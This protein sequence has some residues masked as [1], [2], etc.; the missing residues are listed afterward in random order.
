MEMRWHADG[1]L[2]V[3]KPPSLT[4]RYS[5]PSSL[6][7]RGSH[8]P[9]LSSGHACS[10]LGHMP[11]VNTD[12]DP[13]LEWGILPRE[14]VPGVFLSSEQLVLL[15]SV[16]THFSSDKFMLLVPSLTF[17]S[18]FPV[19]SCS[20]PGLPCR[21]HSSS[22]WLS[23]WFYYLLAAM[24]CGSF[25]A[26]YFSLL[27]ISF[28]PSCLIPQI[29]AICPFSGN[30]T[31]GRFGWAGKSG[32]SGT[33]IRQEPWPWPCSRLCLLQW[34]QAFSTLCAHSLCSLA[35][36]HPRH[37]VALLAKTHMWISLKILAQLSISQ[38]PV[39]MSCPTWGHTSTDMCLGE[40]IQSYH[41]WNMQSNSFLSL[42]PAE[43]ALLLNA[44][45]LDL[46]PGSELVKDEK[47]SINI[48]GS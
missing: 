42:L 20:S 33:Q 47:Y 9:Q 40:S 48:T 36:S 38:Y 32:S 35:P 28:F 26:S 10:V 6:C 2:H 39:L 23:F 43:Q 8:Q 4:L 37:H 25:V 18:A 13:T 1:G 46:V 19:S 14:D 15:F 7:P 45:G 31:L 12:T 21:L 27:F 24:V 41:L 30:L 29:W 3:L 44:P 22:L 5:Q 17:L 34:C 16:C 11:R